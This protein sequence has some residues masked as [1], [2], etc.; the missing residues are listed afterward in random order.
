[1]GH[2]RAADLV[3]VD[4][5]ARAQLSAQRRGIRLRFTNASPAL[6]ELTAFVGLEDALLGRDGRQSEQG[7]QPL[8]VE[9]RV[10]PDDPS[11]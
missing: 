4:A 9:E 7:E 3:T 10:E 8:G 11:A 1:M 5:L 6:R 2:I